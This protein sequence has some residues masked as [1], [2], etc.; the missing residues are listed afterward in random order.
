[1]EQP[2]QEYLKREF[3]HCISNTLSLLGAPEDFVKEIRGVEE[4]PL[5]PQ[6][7]EEINFFNTSTLNN[8]RK[9][10]N[11]YPTISVHVKGH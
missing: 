6:I 10:I 7:I 2:S 11:D 9:I 4:L 5:T 3:V 8:L 1:M